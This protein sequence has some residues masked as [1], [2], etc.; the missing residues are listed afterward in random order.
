[1]RE[2]LSTVAGNDQQ[3]NLSFFNKIYFGLQRSA[4]NE[5]FQETT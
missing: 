3:K 4:K 1:M 5:R 2:K